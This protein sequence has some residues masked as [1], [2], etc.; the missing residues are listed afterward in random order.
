[1]PK[2]LDDGQEAV[3]G[4]GSQSVDRDVSGVGKDEPSELTKPVP[5]LISG[6]CNG[7]L[8]TS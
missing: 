3:E 5:D 8:E 4:D 7:G 2:R 6:S 1:M